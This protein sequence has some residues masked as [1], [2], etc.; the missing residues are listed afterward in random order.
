VASSDGSSTK[1]NGRHALNSL[2]LHT[3]KIGVNYRF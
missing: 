3:I 1:V 2:G